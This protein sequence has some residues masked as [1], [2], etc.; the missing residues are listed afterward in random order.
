MQAIQRKAAEQSQ[1]AKDV[2]R[3]ERVRT[4]AGKPQE[5]SLDVLRQVG[6]GTSSTQAPRNTW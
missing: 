1:T 2:K 5:L 6:G 3:D 4:E